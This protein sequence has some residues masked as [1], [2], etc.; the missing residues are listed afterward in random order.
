[1]IV[2]MN[3]AVVRVRVRLGVCSRVRVVDVRDYVFVYMSVLAWCSFSYIITCS[4]TVTFL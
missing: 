2:Y 1:M 4:S 3:M